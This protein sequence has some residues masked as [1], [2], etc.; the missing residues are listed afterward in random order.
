[1]G[2]ALLTYLHVTFAHIRVVTSL[3]AQTEEPS[4]INGL[5]SASRKLS[6]VGDQGPLTL[7]FDAMM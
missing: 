1:M 2:Y 5:L 6:L 4:F 7:T 3:A